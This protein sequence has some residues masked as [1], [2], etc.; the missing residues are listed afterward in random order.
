MTLTVLRHFND[1]L[2]FYEVGKVF[3]QDIENLYNPSNYLWPFRYFPLGGLPFT[4]FSQLSFEAAFIT[5][6]IFSV[7]INFLICLL[8][9]KISG[10]IS[11][12]KEKDVSENKIMYISLY[13]LALPHVYNYA[14]GQ[15]N[16]LLTFLLLIS[17]Y[18]FLKYDKTV[19]NLIGG[20]LI[21][22]SVNIK[23]ITIFIVPFLITF[24]IYSKVH[25]FNKEEITESLIRVLGVLV[26]IFLNIIFFLLIP[27]LLTGFLEI[28]FIGTETLKINNSFSIT[29]LIINAMTMLNVEMSLLK[30]LQIILFLIILLIMGGTGFLIFLLRKREKNAILYGFILGIVITLLVYFDTWDLHLILLFPL[31]IISILNLE[32]TA[33]GIEEKFFLQ[34]VMKK[35]LYFFLFIDLP[36]FGI[37][38]FVRDVFPYN[39]VPTIFLILLFVSVGRFLLKEGKEN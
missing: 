19:F 27:E 13:L 24:S 35:S 4:P 14:M 26:P 11:Q 22:I 16:S 7:F 39:F 21:G 25:K 34:K 17:L 20:I 38:Y 37:I 30:Q 1:F 36:I 10:L 8:I 29:K 12:N 31:M 33:N 2:V 5:F 23:P 6:N 15:V 32:E 18:I 28:N 3:I 9:Y